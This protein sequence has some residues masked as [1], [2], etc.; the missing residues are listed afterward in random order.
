MDPTVAQATRALD[1]T[2]TVLSNM[3]RKTFDDSSLDKK[4]ARSLSDWLACLTDVGIGEGKQMAKDW[5]RKT[6]GDDDQLRLFAIC[7]YCGLMSA[8]LTVSRERDDNEH[9]E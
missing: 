2:M 9:H 1:E 5:I 3:I 8:F 4:M 7:A 6:M